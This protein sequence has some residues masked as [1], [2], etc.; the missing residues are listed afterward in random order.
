[1]SQEQAITVVALDHCDHR[2]CSTC[3]YAAIKVAQPTSQRDYVCPVPGCSQVACQ[4]SRHV[5]CSQLSSHVFP[6]LL[7]LGRIE[8]LFHMFLANCFCYQATVDFKFAEAQR[9][10]IEDEKAQPELISQVWWRGR[11]R[12]RSCFVPL[13]SDCCPADLSPPCC[14]QSTPFFSKSSHS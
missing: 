6:R 5:C 2:I 1:M 14:S 4:F 11:E 10:K 3:T 12:G 8:S 7:L 9:T 13:G